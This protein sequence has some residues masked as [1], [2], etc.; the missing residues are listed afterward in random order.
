MEID[1]YNAWFH[2]CLAFGGMLLATFIMSRLGNRFY[3]MDP[4]KR[5]V[6]MMALEFPGKE[7]E[8]ANILKGIFLLNDEDRKA[9][10]NAFRWQIILDFLLFMPCT[11]GGIYIMCSTLAPT[12]EPAGKCIFMIFAYAQILCFVLDSIENVYLW[13]NLKPNAKEAGTFTFRLMQLLELLKWSLALISGIGGLSVLCFYWL[14]G[15]YQEG[16]LIY[17]IIFFLEIIVFLLLGKIK[18]KTT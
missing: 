7:T 13:S 18:P 1:I 2:F 16:S 14:S 6:S 15:N 4:L 11:Y 12:L 8:V 17:V 10:L 9:S 5:K 3:T